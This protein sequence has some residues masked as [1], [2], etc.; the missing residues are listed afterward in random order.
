MIKCFVNSYND[1]YID[2]LH[3]LIKTVLLIARFFFLCL[4]ICCFW[5]LRCNMYV[6]Y[7]FYESTEMKRK[8][9]TH[10]YKQPECHSQ[11]SFDISLDHIVIDE[12]HLMLR[13]MDK[14]QSDANTVYTGMVFLTLKDMRQE[15]CT[16]N[17]MLLTKLG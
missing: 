13:V 7:L 9:E 14:V 3:G 15:N 5:C 17:K 1:Q 12:L 16:S 11:P 6:P 4:L 10:W 8:M 2:R